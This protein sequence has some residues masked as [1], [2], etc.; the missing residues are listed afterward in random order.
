MS[1][2]Y[3]I[4]DY[5]STHFEYKYLEKIHI[6]PDIDS[7]IRI[8]R[9]L[10][11]N[12]QRVLTVLGGVQ[13]GYLALVISTASY[14]AI[15]NSQPF[16]RSTLTGS[17]IPSTNRLSATEISQEK[18]AHVKTV[19]IYNEW[20]AVKQALRNQLIDAI[21]PTYLDS[22]RNVDLDMINDYIPT[23]ITFLTTNYCQLTDQEISNREDELKKTTFN[24]EEPVDLIFNRIKEFSE[25]C[26]MTSNDKSD[27][28]L[29]AIGYLIFIRTKAYSDTL[30]KWNTKILADKT[31]ATLKMHLRTEYH[32]LRKVGALV[33]Q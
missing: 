16:D 8:F 9:Q 1:N 10:K 11:R 26:A 2:L 30:K 14:D 18:S 32:A 5:K 31:F 12:A 13:L 29:V 15:A 23:I 3:S 25:L 24:P 19:R 28:Q 27:C 20:H 17:F 6:H 22:L 7:L 21:P 4:R 33:V